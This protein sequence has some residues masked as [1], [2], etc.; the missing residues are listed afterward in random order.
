MK[1]DRLAAQTFNGVTTQVYLKDC[2]AGLTNTFCNSRL[3]GLTVR[4][5]TNGRVMINASI[6]A[7]A[8][9]STHPLCVPTVV[10]LLAPYSPCAH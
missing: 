6:P 4:N 9:A 2:V 1:R 7:Y 5:W 10:L 8:A 3:F